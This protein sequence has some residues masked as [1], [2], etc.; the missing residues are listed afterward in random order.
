[1]TFDEWYDKNWSS[2]WEMLDAAKAA[3]EAARAGEREEAVFNIPET[4]TPIL[5][6]RGVK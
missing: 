2:D 3:W 6:D 1:M 5:F 4:D